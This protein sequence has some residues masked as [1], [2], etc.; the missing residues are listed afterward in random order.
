[1]L[2]QN[3]TDR[4]PG[5]SVTLFEVNCI[6]LALASI[7][8]RRAL[9]IGTFD[10]N[11]SLNLAVNLP[12]DGSVITIDLP[13]SEV[14]EYAIGIAEPSLRNVTERSIVGAQFRNH[15][16]GKKIHQIFCDTGTLDFRSLGGSFDL[17]FIDGCHAYEYVV[18]DTRK[19][20]EVM[21]P[22]GIVIW[23]DYAM[24][25]SVS[26]AVDE[27]QDT[28]VFNDIFAIEGTRLAVGVVNV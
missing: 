28:G 10:G 22:G 4:L 20:L 3:P 5:T 27:M 12:D 24:M 23:H 8:A 14:P 6:L 2:I 19:V 1:L 18:S 9:E 26:R 11:T 7:P 21:A 17:A 15:P 16:A 13:V 25:A